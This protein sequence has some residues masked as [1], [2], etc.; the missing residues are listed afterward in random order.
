MLWG[1]VIFKRNR[2]TGQKWWKGLGLFRQP[3]NW[4][5][6]CI[7]YNSRFSDATPSPTCYLVCGC[8][9]FIERTDSEVLLLFTRCYRAGVA[10][11][12]NGKRNVFDADQAVTNVFMRISSLRS[13]GHKNSKTAVQSQSSSIKWKLKTGVYTYDCLCETTL[14]FLSSHWKESTYFLRI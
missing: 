11:Q 3:I 1:C 12:T 9:P 2:Q 10:L 4:T 6:W 13:H 8:D 7:E 14:F 5:V